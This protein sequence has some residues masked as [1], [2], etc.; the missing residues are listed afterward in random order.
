MLNLYRRICISDF[1]KRIIEEIGEI[2]EKVSFW[3]HLVQP[4]GQGLAWNEG[5]I[6]AVL[7]GP[8]IFKYYKNIWAAYIPQEWRFDLCE[9]FALNEEITDGMIQTSVYLRYAQ[10]WWKKE[11]E[12]KQ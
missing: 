2:Y 1:N 5:F 9:R 6:N 8:K 10:N 4:E 11:M 3:A 12:N 7:D